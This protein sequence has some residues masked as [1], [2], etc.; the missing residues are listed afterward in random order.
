MEDPNENVNV[1]KRSKNVRK[2]HKVPWTTAQMTKLVNRNLYL[3]T[4][5]QEVFFYI[6]LIICMSI[7]ALGITKSTDFFMAENLRKQLIDHTTIPYPEAENT[8]NVKFNEISTV[9]EIWDYLT[10]H[11]LVILYPDEFQHT[12]QS[13]KGIGTENKMVGIPIIRQVMVAPI[14]CPDPF[15]NITEECL[16]SYTTSNSYK[17][18]IEGTNYTYK[19]ASETKAANWNGRISSYGGDGFEI[20]LPRTYEEAEEVLENLKLGNFIRNTTRALFI[21]SAYY[22][23]HV[24]LFT[25]VLIVFEIPPTGGVVPTSNFFTWR[26]PRYTTATDFFVLACEIIFILLI[27]F[28][29]IEE[30]REIIFLR[31][32]FFYEFWNYVD[33]LLIASSIT[34]VVFQIMQHW[35]VHNLLMETSKNVE[36]RIH[37]EEVT[38]GEMYMI[39]AMAI[40]L[41][42]A[43]FKLFRIINFNV[44]TSEIHEAFGKCLLDV[45]AFLVIICIVYFGF[46]LFGG[47]IFGTQ[48]WDFSTFALSLFALS[49]IL[50]GD[51]T[52]DKLLKVDPVMSYIFYYLFLAITFFILLN[53]FLAIIYDCYTDAKLQ[54]ATRPNEKNMVDF[55]TTATYNLLKCCGC[56]FCARKWYFPKKTR[57]NVE[58]DVKMILKRC[59]FSDLDIEMFLSRYNIDPDAKVYTRDVD[60]LVENL[61]S[62]LPQQDNQPSPIPLNLIESDV[63]HPSILKKGNESFTTRTPSV[64]PALFLAQQKRLDMVEGVLGDIG[65]K[66]DL[67]LNKLHVMEARK[68]L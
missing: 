50:I 33:V 66:L 25:L 8:S 55:W 23:P 61:R 65:Y 45:A 43:Y 12:N 19:K 44:S 36:K 53:L 17:K 47:L 48:L 40:A 49:R 11:L 3:A 68:M 24:N 58:D 59:G 54:A 29:T 67:L 9:D 63:H 34:F 22:N 62:E 57:S 13:D 32:R 52:F 6:I 14:K 41:F 39:H 18:D 20:E 42:V 56:G 27:V 64:T 35:E 16:P 10:N 51:L 38:T 30:I 37:L 1:K 26:M 46:A 2:F 4:T 21:T 28:Y 60:K 15:P 31:K 5:A 7:A